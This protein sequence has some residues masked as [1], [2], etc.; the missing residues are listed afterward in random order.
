VSNNYSNDS[1]IK[2]YNAAVYI[3]NKLI[4]KVVAN[5]N[6]NNNNN[7]NISD[8]NNNNNYYFDK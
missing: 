8:N 5:N 1:N 4:Y 2:D 3:I 7:N 6:N